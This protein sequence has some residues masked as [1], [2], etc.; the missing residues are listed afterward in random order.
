MDSKI[1]NCCPEIV[2]DKKNYI[3][4][5]IKAI[6]CTT[7]AIIIFFVPLELFGQDR[8]ILFGTIINILINFLGSTWL[9]FIVGAVTLNSIGFIIGKYFSKK[10]SWL[11]EYYAE[12]SH[13]TGI[14]YLMGTAYAI[15]YAFKIGPHL[16]YSHEVGGVVID[17]VALQVG[18]ILPLGGMLVPLLLCFGGLEFVGTF[19]EPLMRPIFKLPG[20]SALNAIASFVG[21]SSIGVYLTSRIYRENQYTQREAV[22][23][24]TCFSAVSVGFAALAADT[25][26]LMPVFPQV[27]FSSIIIAFLIA[28]VLVRIPPISKKPDIYFDGTVQTDEDR[29][30]NVKFNLDIFKIAVNRAVE[31]SH[32]SDSIA[33]E[34][35]KGLLDGCTLIPKVVALVT[36]IGI[37]GLLVAQ[38]TPIFTWLSIPMIPYLKLFGIPN[39]AQV[40]PS[41]LIGITEMY[42]PVLVIAG[43]GLEIGARYFVTVLA[44]VQILF[45]SETIA[46][47][48]TTGLP[49][50]LK[51]TLILFIQR[52]LVA[53]PIIALFMHIL[54]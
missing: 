37:S 5:L 46:V 2:F 30:P 12:D 38:Y 53:I 10:G 9:W 25:V 21:S 16:I 13:I 22:C 3:K 40:A 23:I 42:L 43:K 29:K 7:A 33:K 26:D 32:N 45:F 54:F 17:S 44:L 24:A 1:T 19:I 47:I 48:L 4:N 14:L 36:S 34:L 15:M 18:W 51:E 20:T 31:K 27:Y 39:A 50:N 41:T 52:T 35:W 49:V 6:L 28:F 8:N 11:N